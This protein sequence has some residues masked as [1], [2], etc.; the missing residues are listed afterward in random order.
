[1]QRI[2]EQAI[3]AQQRLGAQVSAKIQGIFAADPSEPEKKRRAASES[4]SSALPTPGEEGED[5]QRPPFTN[6]QLS[7]LGKAVAQS[8]EATLTI[9]GE[10]IEARF[11]TLE[12]KFSRTTEHMESVDDRLDKLEK[13]EAAVSPEV[14]DLT[15][16]LKD[17]KKKIQK[18]MESATASSSQHAQGE[19]PYESRTTAMMGNLGF[20]TPSDEL[21][22]RCK[23]LLKE[24]GFGPE[25]CSGIACTRRDGGSACEIVF[26][27]PILLQQARLKIKA[28]RKEII[29]GRCVWL[30]AKKTRS[31]MRPNRM[32]HRIHECLEQFEAEYSENHAVGKAVTKN[33]NMKNVQTGGILMGF[34]KAG[35]WHWTKAAKERYTE[36]QI[37]LA[38]SY[39][40][41]A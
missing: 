22:E 15:E 12:A 26:A 7:W 17:L 14:I 23:T 41:Q 32:T 18:D 34:C 37:E 11:Q 38:K 29:T 36:D 30:D 40:E 21:E 5:S 27:N 28:K 24:C 10:H 20:D 39:A 9:F 19:A 35:A 1:M 8:Q 6:P 3:L 16:Q 33:L 2:S 13:R 4:S 25:H 31:E